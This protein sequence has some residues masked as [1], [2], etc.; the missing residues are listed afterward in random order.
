LTTSFIVGISGQNSY[1]KY[2]CFPKC[3]SAFTNIKIFVIFFLRQ[4]FSIGK[5]TIFA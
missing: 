1:R 5:P 3:R 2:R 4:W